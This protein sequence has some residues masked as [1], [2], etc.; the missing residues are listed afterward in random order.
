MIAMIK[1]AC[2]VA[3]GFVMAAAAAFVVFLIRTRDNPFSNEEPADSQK[4]EEQ[5]IDDIKREVDIIKSIPDND[6]RRRAGILRARRALRRSRV[7]RL[8]RANRQR[9]ADYR[10]DK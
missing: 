1:N 6:N 8:R 9:P 7:A 3:T 10:I 2:A 4:T 5:L